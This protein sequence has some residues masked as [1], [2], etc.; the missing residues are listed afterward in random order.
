MSVCFVRRNAEKGGTGIE[1]G[2]TETARLTR[3][4]EIS[5]R[6]DVYLFSGVPI[7]TLERTD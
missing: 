6:N 3:Q 4:G 2:W 5:R 1:E 7:E